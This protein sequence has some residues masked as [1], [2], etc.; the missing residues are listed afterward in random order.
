M[1]NNER[2]I[3]YIGLTGGFLDAAG[4]GGWGPVA[5]PVLMSTTS[6]E[7]RKV[8]GTVNAA[9]FLIAVSASIGFLLNIS[10]IG[11]DWQVVAGLAIGGM[12][13][14][15]IA[16][17]LVAKMPKLWLGVLVAIGIILINGYRIIVG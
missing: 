7:P 10:K 9:E 13:I 4:G 12:I 6:I 16:A 14:A 17:K 8:V 15:P 1:P 2:A 11:F 3:P 5:T